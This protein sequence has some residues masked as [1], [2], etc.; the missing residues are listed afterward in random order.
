MALISYFSSETISAFLRRSNYW[1]K[2][3]RNAYPVQI[4]NAIS[5]LYEWIDCPCDD[6]CECK[7]YQCT[8]HLVRKR[9]ITFDVYYNHFLNCYV[10]TKAHDAVRQGRESGRG[11]R[12][13]AATEK[14][15]DIW[16][17]VS[18]ISSEKHLICTN[19]CE[20]IHESLGRDFRPSSD[21]IYYAKWLSLLCFDT[22]TAYD[23]AS[24]ALMKRDFNKPMDYFD[25]MMGIRQDI[26][27]HLSNTGATL[28]NFREYDNPSEFFDE[29]P[30]NSPRP[31]GNIVDKLY[32]TL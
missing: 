15:R 9:D 3:N 32:L 30:I 27:K 1:A 12:A 11:K 20:P 8:K 29:I 14:I 4:H 22:F 10:D 25:L 23:N 21:T 19:W 24:V 31:I 5:D 18:A 17:E 13:V 7:N 2:Q 28:Q 16:S 26:I 6:D